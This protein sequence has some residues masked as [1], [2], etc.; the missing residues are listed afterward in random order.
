MAKSTGMPTWLASATYY[1][2]LLLGWPL[3]ILLPVHVDTRRN[4]PRRSKST[5]LS[6]VFCI[7]IQLRRPARQQGELISHDPGPPPP[8][9]VHLRRL[10]ALALLDKSRTL[11][12]RRWVR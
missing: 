2:Y 6:S 9:A 8:P 1:Y 10:A 11:I 7:F 4:T 3:S 5:L 12:P